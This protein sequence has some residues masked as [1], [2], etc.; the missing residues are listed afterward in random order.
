M[1]LSSSWSGHEVFILV[2]WV[3][4][5]QESPLLDYGQRLLG[6]KGDMGKSERESTREAS[7]EV[8]M[9]AHTGRLP[10]EGQRATFICESGVTAD[11]GDSKSPA[12]ACG[13]ESHLSHQ[14]PF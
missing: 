4:V 6:N 1:A 8:K 10:V 12:S 7:A 5:P 11:T 14:P 2:T 3:R 13:F 9:R